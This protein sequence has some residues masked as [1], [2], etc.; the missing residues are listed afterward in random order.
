M[1][2]NDEEEDEEEYSNITFEDF[3]V[4]V[5][6]TACLGLAFGIMMALGTKLILG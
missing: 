5:F 6:I 3:I 4:M 2:E 1:E